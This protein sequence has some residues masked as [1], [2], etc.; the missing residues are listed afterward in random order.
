M[1]W[2]VDPA[3]PLEIKLGIIFQTQCLTSEQTLTYLTAV[4]LC[5]GDAGGHSRLHFHIFQQTDQ[6]D[7]F[8]GIDICAMCL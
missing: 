2:A 1:K 4:I 6:L 7:G 5:H 8:S 3:L